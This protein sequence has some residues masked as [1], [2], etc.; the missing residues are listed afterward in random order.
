[1]NVNRRKLAG[2]LRKA[3]PFNNLEKEHIDLLLDNAE[4]VFF[5]SEKMVYLEGTPALFFYILYQGQVE[6]M[7][8]K[9]HALF[10]L[11]NLREGFSFGE[12]ALTKS[13]KRQTSARAITD[14]ILIKISKEILTQVGKRNTAFW[15]NTN[16]MITSY[17]YLV[18]KTINLGKDETVCY[19]GQ[20]HPI[21]VV[22]KMVF[23]LLAVFGLSILLIILFNSGLLTYH[24]LMWGGGMLAVTA[25]VWIGWQFLEWSND[26]FFFTDKRIINKQRSLFSYEI[27]QETPIS[28]IESVQARRSF[29]GRELDFGD[30]EIRTF[31]GSMRLPF[32]PEISSVQHMLTYLTERRKD[33]WEAEEKQTFEKDI[34]ERITQR[35]SVG[36]TGFENHPDIS[37]SQIS[38]PDSTSQSLG[39]LEAPR[40]IVYRTH[41]TILFAKM[42][43]PMLLLISHMLLY[44][45]LAVN[46][47]EIIKN[48]AFNMILLINSIVLLSW[49]AYSFFDW[50]NDVYIITEDQLIDIDR[51]PFGME[52]K[53]A[54]P[55]NN[56]QSIRYKRNGIFGLLL[57]FGTVY[58]RIGDEEFTFDNV[59]RPAEVQEALFTAK[60]RFHQIE[61][62]AEKSAQRKKAVDWIDSYHQIINE[63]HGN[64]LNNSSSDVK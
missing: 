48:T 33:L 30:L 12:D 11:N 63:K 31:T 5:P 4:I 23:A 56:I 52:E 40:D 45:F 7:K 22:L 19:I 26:L 59:H 43:I 53:R 15:N 20:P 16:T 47:I 14:V 29:L 32:V 24:I 64:D 9:H 44:L 13:Q 3:F 36:E 37:S 28:A 42:F 25:I 57:N 58:T 21:I 10:Q 54:A 41:W 46:Q 51:R 60:E 17:D 38:S 49:S 35:A 2:T 8:E 50:R 18:R 62:D 6:I 27:K 34:R 55:I 1:M 61:E 39:D